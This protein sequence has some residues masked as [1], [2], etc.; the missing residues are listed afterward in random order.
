MRIEQVED[1]ELEVQA[2]AQ[3]VADS[4]IDQRGRALGS[5]PINRIPKLAVS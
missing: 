2:L 3:L 4:G 1:V 5:G